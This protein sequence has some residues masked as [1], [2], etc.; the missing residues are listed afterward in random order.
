MNK[1]EGKKETGNISYLRYSGIGFQ[2]AAIVAFGFWLGYELDSYLHTSAP[3]FTMA[4]SVTFLIVAL[5][6]GLKDFGK[7]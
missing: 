2:I 4:F 5:Y 1:K 7:K 6:T 3:Y